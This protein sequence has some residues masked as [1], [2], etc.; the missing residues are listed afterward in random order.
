MR[1]T[2]WLA[3]AVSAAP[4]GAAAQ[5]V[6]LPPFLELR[7]PK[8]PTV[9]TADGASFLVYEM[10][11]T[12]FATPPVT[13][14][15]VEV[16]SGKERGSGRVMLTLADSALWRNLSRP[17]TDTPIGER[18]RLAGGARAVVWLWVPVERS[19][20]PTLIVTRLVLEQGS[21]DSLRTRELDS[22]PTP[23]SPESSPR[24]PRLRRALVS[25][26]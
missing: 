11:V 22:P 26:S 1:T 12:N 20:L 5:G 24:P 14:K 15:R 17:G 8:S 23:V 6:S 3:L 21:G 13:I 25:K 18:A 7:I 19:A 16:A 2:L 10:H 9:A 4:A